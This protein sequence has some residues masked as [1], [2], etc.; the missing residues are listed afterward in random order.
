MSVFFLL[1][2]LNHCKK[3]FNNILSVVLYDI[4]PSFNKFL[5]ASVI[6]ISLFWLK[7]FVQRNR[8]FYAILERYTVLL[9]RMLNKTDANLTAQSPES[10]EKGK[11]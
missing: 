6:E 9:C 8:Q 2:K 5:H 11:S 7:E 10:I 1:F 3:L 4:L